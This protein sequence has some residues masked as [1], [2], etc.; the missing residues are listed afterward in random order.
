[1]EKKTNTQGPKN[2]IL[3]AITGASGIQ[4]AIKILEYLLAEG[5]KTELIISK[6]AKEVIKA[7]TTYEISEI[8]NLATIHYNEGDLTAPPASGS[9]K[10]DSM[11]IVPCSMKTLSAIANGY[12]NNLITRAADVALKEQRKLILMVRETPFNAIHL[13]NMLKL[14]KLGVIIAPPIPSY[15]IKPKSVDDLI[16]QTAGR[17]LN[18]LDIDVNIKRWGNI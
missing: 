12:A 4:V 5:R 1:M 10:S 3:I 16:E 15:Y 9:H 11:I 13:E 6:I 8:Y 18:L 14:A 17:M 2:S 7:E